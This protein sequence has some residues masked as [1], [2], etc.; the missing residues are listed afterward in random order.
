MSIKVY[1]SIREEESRVTLRWLVWATGWIKD[2]Y[3]DINLGV[4]GVQMTFKTIRFNDTN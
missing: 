3:G 4:I 2:A 1:K